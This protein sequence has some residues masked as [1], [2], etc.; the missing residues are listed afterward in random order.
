M[1]DWIARSLELQRRHRDMA[2]AGSA[3][4]LVAGPWPADLTHVR[5]LRVRTGR[6]FDVWA[7]DAMGRAKSPWSCAAIPRAA[8]AVKTAA[9]GNYEN[10]FLAACRLR[11]CNRTLRE[12]P[13]RVDT[14]GNRKSPVIYS[15]SPTRGPY[16][17][18]MNAVK[19]SS[20]SMTDAGVV[21]RATAR[22]ARCCS[23]AIVPNRC[24]RGKTC[25]QLIGVACNPNALTSGALL[26]TSLL[27]L[28]V[29]ELHHEASCW[30]MCAGA[31]GIVV[32]QTIAPRAGIFC[33]F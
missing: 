19:Q 17:T 11:D 10:V 14:L 33:S 32:S 15:Y 18:G 8:V 9:V 4:T 28:R 13:A 24:T 6:F 27:V 31:S 2:R 26:A 29:S 3:D 20:F 23:R 25:T 5:I 30:P 16:L 22:S 7:D 12:C 21:P 1:P